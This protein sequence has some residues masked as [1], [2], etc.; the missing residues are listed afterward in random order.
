MVADN[1]TARKLNDTGHWRME[2][3][4][5]ETKAALKKFFGR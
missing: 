4:P 3:R 2:E 5:A 1:I